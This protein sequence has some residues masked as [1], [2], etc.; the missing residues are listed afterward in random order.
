[1]LNSGG[2]FSLSKIMA[3]L[4]DYVDELDQLALSPS[5]DCLLIKLR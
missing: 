3:D 1:M 2:F 5:E 4:P